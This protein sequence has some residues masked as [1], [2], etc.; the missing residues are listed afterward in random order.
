MIKLYTWST[1][2]GWKAS[3]M[4][5]E[6]G[7]PYE[8]HPIDLGRRTQ[9][10]EWFRRISPYG[11]IPA[12]V[13]TEL[14]N[15]PLA[16]SGAILIHLAE[17]AGQLLST[18]RAIR[19]RTLQWLLFQVGAVGPIQGQA[20]SFLRYIETESTVARDRFAAEILRIYGVLDRQLAD[21]EYL[22]GEYSIADIATFPWVKGHSWAGIDIAGFPNVARWLETVNSRAA[23]VRGLAIPHR[24]DLGD[25]ATKASLARQGRG[26]VS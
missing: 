22:A 23:V 16:E 2:N 12:I 21:E 13:D 1:P 25:S 26:L 10:E 9:K 24:V 7:L 3:I 18:D 19:S 11:K 8:L 17:K 5:E 20:V 15:F 14:D 4:L 6:T